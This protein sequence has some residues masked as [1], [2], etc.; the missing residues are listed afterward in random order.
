M[1]S[2]FRRQ[3]ED[4][5]LAFGRLLVSLGLRPN[6]LTICG[7]LLGGLTA[8]ALWVG[9]IFLGV[10]LALLSV[11]FDM[12]DGAAARGSGMAWPMGEVYDHL[13]DRY[14]E[15]CI[16]LGLVGGG[17]VPGWLGL[18]TVFGMVM[19]SYTRVKAESKYPGADHTFG[20]MERQEKLA[21]LLLGSV[22][23]GLW[24]WPLLLWVPVGLAGLFSHLTVVQ[25]LARVRR[26]ARLDLEAARGTDR[27]FTGERDTDA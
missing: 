21:L 1:L 11:A 12:A 20:V 24:N 8:Y 16:V 15:F 22:L 19:A 10:G 2:K 18:V 17:H 27:M 5:F 4:R 9:R 7:L 25:R 3:Y 23:Y 26:A 13:A 6:L 14:V